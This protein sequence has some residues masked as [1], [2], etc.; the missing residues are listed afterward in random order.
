MK[1]SSLQFSFVDETGVFEE[2]KLNSMGIGALTVTQNNFEFGQKMHQV[3]IATV[4][5]LKVVEERYEFKFKYITGTNLPHYYALLN[6][7]E[8]YEGNW[9]FNY[10]FTERNHETF[11]DQYLNM[12]E[13]LFKEKHG[14]YV[15]LADYLNKPKKSSRLLPNLEGKNNITKILQLESQGTVFLQAADVLLGAVSFHKNQRRD[16]YKAGV[17][18]RAL[19][20]LKI[21]K[22]R[23]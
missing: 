14:Q 2:S 17:A 11:W 22:E 10:L 1:K 18:D 5:A 9:E 19:K 21:K 20:I 13:R 15:V 16:R 4:D 7:L 12:L 23:V 8:E 3:F 6:V